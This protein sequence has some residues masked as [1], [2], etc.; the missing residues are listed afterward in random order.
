[1]NFNLMACHVMH[2]M[3]LIFFQLFLLKM[4]LSIYSSTAYMNVSLRVEWHPPVTSCEPWIMIRDSIQCSLAKEKQHALWIID[5][6]LNSIT[7]SGD[8]PTLLNSNT[9]LPTS[10]YEIRVHQSVSHLTNIWILRQVQD[11]FW[12][13]PLILTH[14]WIIEDWVESLINELIII[15]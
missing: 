6:T 7:W 11:L 14:I 8:V 5:P 10:L 12:C 1:M 9:L 2:M 15:H 3:W 4:H 13:T